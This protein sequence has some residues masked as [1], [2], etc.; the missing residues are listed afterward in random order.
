MLEQGMQMPG[1][2]IYDHELSK[3]QGEFARCS[4]MVAQRLRMHAILDLQ[5]GDQVLEIGSGNGIMA[6]EMAAA[7][8]AAGCV[9]GA[10]ISG[11]MVAMARAHCA[12]LPN[13]Y[14]VEADAASL[15]F[16]DGSFDVITITQCLCLVSDI[17]AAAA[18]IY[19]V[20]RP[21]GRA[22]ILETDW[23]TL[24]WNSTNPILM[25]KIMGIYKGVYVDARLPRRLGRILKSAGLEITGHDH[26]AMLNWRFEPE[27]FSGHQIGFVKE[28][29]A[30]RDDL[31]AAELSNWEQ[32]IKAKSDADEYFF[33]LNRYIFCCKKQ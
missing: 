27:T 5:P 16:P 29:M 22:V 12:Q 25:D 10:D 2:M 23:D 14:F 4:D 3:K 20:L 8:G 7:V 31:T 18:E 6:R 26:I 19:R 11:T 15:P 32:S 33:N 9:T 30:P 24:I 21:G 13:A 1:V 17:D 28:L